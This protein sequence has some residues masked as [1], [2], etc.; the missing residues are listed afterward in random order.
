MHVSWRSLGLLAGFL[1][2]G[3]FRPGY[4]Q[5]NNQNDCKAQDGSTAERTHRQILVRR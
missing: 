5:L 2:A 3:P 4:W 1:I